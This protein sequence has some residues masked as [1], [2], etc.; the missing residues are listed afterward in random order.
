MSGC[1][2]EEAIGNESKKYG[3]SVSGA[4][5]GVGRAAR[6]SVSDSLGVLYQLAE[7]QTLLGVC[8][9]G[10]KTLVNGSR[11]KVQGSRFKWCAR[12]CE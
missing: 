6:A 8:F 10:V 12:C 9:A 4:G 5:Q 2:Q 7:K 3:S 11:F 1:S